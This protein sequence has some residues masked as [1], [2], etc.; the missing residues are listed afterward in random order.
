MVGPCSRLPTA[1]HTLC[2]HSHLV[3][4]FTPRVHIQ[5]LCSHAHLAFTCTPCVHIHTLCS[6]SRLVFAFTPRVHVHTS[7]S[8]SHLVIT[9]HTFST[10]SISRL[11][12]LAGMLLCLQVRAE[13]RHLPSAGCSRQRDDHHPG[14]QV[15]ESR[16]ARPRHADRPCRHPHQVGQDCRSVVRQPPGRVPVRRSASSQTGDTVT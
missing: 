4:T 7:C 3:F 6:H 10:K 1:A 11:A 8:H 9:I 14:R 12:L 5:T 16:Q 13:R 2:S 15:Q